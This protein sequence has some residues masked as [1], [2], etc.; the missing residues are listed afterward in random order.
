[1]LEGLSK[2][3]IIAG[4]KAAYARNE[5]PALEPGAM[6]YMLS[7]HAWLSDREPHSLAHLMFYTPLMDAAN[8]GADKNDT[9]VGLLQQFRGAPEPINTFI[10]ATGKWSDGTP[11]P[12]M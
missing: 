12:L 3:Q 4:I 9:P 6:A 2:E 1:V 7:K 10:V 8:W 11:A 5:L